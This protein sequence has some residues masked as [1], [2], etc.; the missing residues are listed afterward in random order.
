MNLVEIVALNFA[1]KERSSGTNV[2][3]ILS[4]AGSDQAILDPPIGPFDLAFG[5]GREGIGHLDAT[6]VQDLFPLRI[7]LVGEQMMFTPQGVPSLDEAKDGMGVDVIGE[8]TTV[9]KENRL[10][11]HDMS[12]G[13]L[14]FEEGGIEDEAAIIIEGGNQI[15]LLLSRWSPEVVG[16]I[17]LNQLTDVLG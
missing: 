1:I 3:D 6:I 2:S 4:H 7:H 9:L 12:P 10:K 8:R 14:S 13:G 16:G 11:R 17:M 5:L 15:P